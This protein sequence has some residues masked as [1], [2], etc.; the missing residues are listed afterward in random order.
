V[1]SQ[2]EWMCDGEPKNNN[3]PYYTSGPH[4][5]YKN[6]GPLCMVCGLPREAMEPP[7]TEP[8]HPFKL[9]AIAAIV[10]LIIAGGGFAAYKLLSPG[11][12]AT[13][14]NTEDIETSAS[15]F[16]S[17]NAANAQFISRGEKI[18]FNSTPTKEEAAQAFA[19]EDWAT[20][21]QQYETAAQ[22]QQNDPESKIYLNNAKARQAGNAVTIAVVV[23]L[24]TNPDAAQEV[25]RGVGLY[26]EQYNQNP[27]LPDQLLEVA[28]AI[29]DRG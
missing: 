16:I 18:L 11:E 10:A 2:G 1:S 29:R 6:T 20:A 27:E 22:E 12:T 9:I 17:E 25:L 5:P 7:K 26:Q 15:T 19:T 4:A 3:K 13:R 23:P 24:S 21:I 14:Y 28:I 8:K